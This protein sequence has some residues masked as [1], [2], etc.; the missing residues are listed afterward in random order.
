MHVFGWSDTCKWDPAETMCAVTTLTVGPPQRWNYFVSQNFNR[1][2]YPISNAFSN[3]T[4]HTNYYI[5][6]SA[7]ENLISVEVVS[8]SLVTTSAVGVSTRFVKQQTTKL[9][10][11][12]PL[13]V[14]LQILF[15]H[16]MCMHGRPLTVLFVFWSWNILRQSNAIN[17]ILS[18][19][20][21]VRW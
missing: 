12:I 3:C 9:Y 20:V 13:T 7:D 6:K 5:L 1:C 15:W 17:Q 21:Q 8:R 14:I 19:N 4:L 11:L 16:K 10:I 18:G 2:H